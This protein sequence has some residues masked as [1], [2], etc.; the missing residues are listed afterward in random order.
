MKTDFDR[1]NEPYK[2][3]PAQNKKALALVGIGLLFVGCVL[4]GVLLYIMDAVRMAL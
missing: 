1:I 4:L 2:T 3:P